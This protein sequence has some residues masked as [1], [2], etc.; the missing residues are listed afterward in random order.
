[1]DIS[2]GV[3]STGTLTVGGQNGDGQ[4][5]AESGKGEGGPEASLPQC[6]STPAADPSVGEWRKCEHG[7]DDS[8]TDMVNWSFSDREFGRAPG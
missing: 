2:P 1:M 8:P 4:D 5:E 6:Y 7:M 3:Q